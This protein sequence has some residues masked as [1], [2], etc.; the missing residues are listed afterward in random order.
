MRNKNRLVVVSNRVPSAAAV[1][2]TVVDRANPVGGLV[3]AVRPALEE[4]EGVWFGWSG[5]T[6]QRRADESPKVA[7]MG[8]FQLATID[9]SEDEVNLYYTGFSNRTLW[10]LL[11]GF[12]ERVV[13]RHDTYRAYRRI[14]RRFAEALL[15]MLEPGDLVWVHDFHMFHVG[16][17]LRRLGWEGKIGFFLHVPFPPSDVFSIIPWARSILQALLHYDLIGLHTE[18]YR[19][20]LG[21]TLESQLQAERIDGVFSTD[22]LSSKL[23]VY[24]MGIDPRMFQRAALEPGARGLADE[25]RLGG[26]PNHQ[27][28][29]GVDR[30]DYTKGIPARIRAFE[31]LLEHHAWL[32]GRVTLVQVSAPSRSRVPEYRQEKERV[33]ML[34]G[35]INGRFSEAG[36]VP[37]RSLYRSY[38]QAELARFYY[39]AHVAMVTPL[40]DG[41]NLVAKEFIAAQGEDPGVLVLSAFAGAASTMTEAVIVNP[42][43]VDGTAEATYQALRM[44]AV[45]RRRRWRVLME[46]VE[47]NTARTWG[48]EFTRDLRDS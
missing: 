33:D 6:T 30:L 46:E 26:S 12:T 48:D 20:N 29:L 13:V 44:P 24:H 39:D 16:A 22:G 18:G 37:I 14:N 36:W 28:I 17:E 23:G 27:L 35:Q 43:D 4:A 15:T 45:E 41:L 7:S 2:T 31:R 42:Y 10:P 25:L 38:P 5:K 11:H 32:R 9:L 1:A 19:H 8:P 47:G 40:R 34:V 21:E 3:S